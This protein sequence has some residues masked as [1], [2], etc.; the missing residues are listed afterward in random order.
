[1]TSSPGG[2]VR[3]RVL[4][5]VLLAC[6]LVRPSSAA[7]QPFTQ[8]SARLGV[9][10][11]EGVGI[12][13]AYHSS[14]KDIDGWVYGAHPVRVADRYDRHDRYGRYADDDYCWDR[15]WDLRWDDG[16]YGWNDYGYD[17]LDF[18]HDCLRGGLDY[19]YDQWR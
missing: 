11:F 19:A 2:F 10:V 16:Y 12:G 17:H 18:Y 5:G 8:F 7:A 3:S 4:L 14:P 15:S 9:G 13:L 6:T 1:M